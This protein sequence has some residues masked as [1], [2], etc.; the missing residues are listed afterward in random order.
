M[1]TVLRTVLLCYYQSYNNTVRHNDKRRYSS[2]NR[3][4]AEIISTAFLEFVALI[5][6][7]S[8]RM[9]APAAE[10]A[11]PYRADKALGEDEAGLI[12]HFNKIIRSQ[13]TEDEAGILT[14]ERTVT[15]VYIA[16]LIRCTHPVTVSRTL[17]YKRVS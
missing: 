10:Y 15:T 14:T 2:R 16:D 9:R 3:R 12:S 7:N 4:A 11:V 1:M 8:L 13:T 6:L 17:T 5:A